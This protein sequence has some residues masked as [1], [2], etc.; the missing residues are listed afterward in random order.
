MPRPSK[1]WE[2][3]YGKTA[4]QQNKPLINGSDDTISAVRKLSCGVSEAQGILFQALRQTK[5]PYHC[6]FAIDDMQL[7]GDKIVRAYHGW[8]ERNY[9]KLLKGIKEKDPSLVQFVAK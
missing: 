8:A 5:E 7:H 9:E 3:R 6:L 1:D 4:Q 2:R